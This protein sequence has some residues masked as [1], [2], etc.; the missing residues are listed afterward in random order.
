[1]TGYKTSINTNLM[2]Q[3]KDFQYEVSLID[4]IAGDIHEEWRSSWKKDPRNMGGNDKRIKNDEDINQN[5]SELKCVENKQEN[6]MSATVALNCVIRG[7]ARECAA[8]II[9][10]TWV[11][12][13]KSYATALQMQS[14]CL[15]PENEK[16][17]DRVIFD[18]AKSHQY[19]ALN[20]VNILND[21]S[22]DHLSFSS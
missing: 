3:Q 2:G 5:F 4:V 22:V 9:H 14:Y 12:R 17:K 8:S 16:E 20:I 11:Q 15:L 13:N 21:E 10:D 7:M 1:M 6:L 19:T 18:I